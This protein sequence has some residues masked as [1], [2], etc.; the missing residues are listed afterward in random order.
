MSQTQIYQNEF[1]E[2][3]PQIKLKDS[4]DCDIPPNATET[5]RNQKAQ[6]WLQTQFY[7]KKW[8]VHEYK[9]KIIQK[10]KNGEPIIVVNYVNYSEDY[11][12]TMVEDILNSQEFGDDSSIFV[13]VPSIMDDT[14]NSIHDKNST[15]CI[16]L[17]TNPLK[18]KHKHH[19]VKQGSTGIFE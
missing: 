3:Q 7:E 10:A 6:E 1:K 4:Y 5:L 8:E 18:W 2:H 13:V 17:S 16:Q 14:E 12:R 15:I 9:D 11:L 19:P